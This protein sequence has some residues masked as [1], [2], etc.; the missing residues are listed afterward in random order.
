MKA[1]T[2]AA[3]RDQLECLSAID[4]NPCPRSLE[5]C[6]ALGAIQMS[7]K[8]EVTAAGPPHPFFLEK[9]G[10]IAFAGIL[11]QGLGFVLSQPQARI[12]V[13]RAEDNSLEIA[14]G[15]FSQ[16]LCRFLRRPVKIVLSHVSNSDRYE[17]QFNA[18]GLYTMFISECLCNI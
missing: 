2:G 11:Q 14:Q 6:K 5:Y 1:S 13:G 10:L 17:I 18:F 12:F 15:L 8:P 7:E 16:R 3:V 4:W 9:S